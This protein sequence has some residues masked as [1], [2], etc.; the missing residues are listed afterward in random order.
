MAQIPHAS[1]LSWSWVP[2]D[3]FSLQGEVSPPYHET[4][5]SDRDLLPSQRPPLACLRQAHQVLQDVLPCDDVL[6][7]EL[8][9]EGHLWA[10]G[11]GVLGALSRWPSSCHPA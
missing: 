10:Q 2:R 7:A 1:P 6:S 5:E 9:G 4:V 3:S 8:L 11:D